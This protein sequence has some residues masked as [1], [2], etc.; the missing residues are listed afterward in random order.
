M[1]PS[2]NKR[3]PFHMWFT[4]E[5]TQCSQSRYNLPLKRH[6]AAVLQGEFVVPLVVRSVVFRNWLLSLLNRPRLPESPADMAATDRAKSKDSG[7]VLSDAFQPIRSQEELL[8]EE[9]QARTSSKRTG[10]ISRLF[11]S[12]PS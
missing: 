6:V 8:Q 2:L 10:V 11:D 12:D 3:R 1:G 7:R 5:K 9:V 4:N